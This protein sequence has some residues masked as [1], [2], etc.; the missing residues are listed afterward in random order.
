MQL[1]SGHARGHDFLKSLL[2]PGGFGL[3]AGQGLIDLPAV[4]Q[5]VGQDGVNVGQVERLEPPSDFF[6][7]RAGLVS[8]DHQ[9]QE[10]PRV[11]DTDCAVFVLPERQRIGL[12]IQRHLRI[13]MGLDPVELN[14]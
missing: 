11:A 10:Y 2:L 3:A 14:V 12:E 8:A 6:G 13:L 9:L 5:V 1:V 7:G 4:P